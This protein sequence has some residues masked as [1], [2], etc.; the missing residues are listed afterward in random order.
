MQNLKKQLTNFKEGDIILLKEAYILPPKPE[1]FLGWAGM[2]GFFYF[3]YT[4]ITV[5]SFITT[6]VETNSV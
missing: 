4:F 2:R 3:L 6:I 5:S 1:F